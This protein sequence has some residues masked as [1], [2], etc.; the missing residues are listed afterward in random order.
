MH[1]IE[2][3]LQAAQQAID[4]QHFNTAEA[5]LRKALVRAPQDARV[6]SMLRAVL[7]HQGRLA[8]ALPLAERSVRLSPQSADAWYDLARCYAET[9]RHEETIAAADRVLALSPADGHA[10]ILKIAALIDLCRWVE[11]EA[12]AGESAA[13]CPDRFEFLHAQA[14]ALLTLGRCEESAQLMGRAQFLFPSQRHIAETRCFHETAGWLVDRKAVF[15]THVHY[16]RMI[17][18]EFVPP[19]APQTDRDP[20]RRLR[21]AFI[22]PDL[23]EHSVAYY[24]EAFFRHHDRNRF[25]VAAYHMSDSTDALTARL[26]AQVSLFRHR[27]GATVP[28]AVHTIRNDRIDILVDLAGLTSGSPA[29]IMQARG[30]PVQATYLGYPNTT[31]IPNIDYRIVD[32]IT[33][34]PEDPYLADAFS[35]E[36]LVRIDPCFLCYTPPPALLAESTQR[37]DRP[38]VVFGSFNASHKLNARLLSLWKRV[39]D[40][41]PGSSLVLK[42]VLFKEEQVRRAFAEMCLNVGIGHDRFRLLP[43]AKSL[44]SHLSAY[45]EVDIALDTFP[46]HGTTTTCEALLMGTPVVTFGGWSHA[47][48]VGVSLLRNAGTPELIAGNEDEYVRIAA[49]L[50]ADHS[51]YT[52]YHRS[53]R[54]RVLGSAVCDGPAFAA[55]LGDALRAM[56]R[57]YCLHG[58]VAP[59]K[60]G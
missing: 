6:V 60:P 34:P 2:K 14:Q 32:S 35:T 30:A 44:A 10:R 37:P 18:D 23:R 4:S 22:S 57:T 33:D 39:L 12:F 19:A 17:A 48:R 13:I 49:A 40:A 45:R 27:L 7:T 52:E 26:A 8:D 47:S 59:S 1:E 9:D 5:R 58:H 20:D 53:L 31:G 3:H 38:G 51:R 56:W 15:N 46:Y 21:I 55:R 11:V 54:E 25:F 42:A 43:P 24:I 41:T 29:L 50:G 36:R 28:E 16:G